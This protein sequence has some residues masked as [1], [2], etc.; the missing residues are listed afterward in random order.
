MSA[1]GV[2]KGNAGQITC[3][4]HIL[5]YLNVKD[6]FKGSEYEPSAVRRD[7]VIFKFLPALSTMILYY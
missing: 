2:G 4:T 5:E 6:T 3:P 1:A 7:A